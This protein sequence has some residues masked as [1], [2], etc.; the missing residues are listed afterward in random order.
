[1][2]PIHCEVCS[3]TIGVYERA[4]AIHADGTDFVGAREE[5]RYELQTPGTIAVH[6]QCYRGPEPVRHSD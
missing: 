6:E 1:M 4:R 3:E 5:L 2:E